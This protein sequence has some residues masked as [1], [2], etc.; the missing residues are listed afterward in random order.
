MKRYKQY[1]FDGDPAIIPRTAERHNL[2]LNT[3]DTEVQVETEENDLMDIEQD[4]FINTDAQSTVIEDINVENIYDGDVEDTTYGTTEWN[5]RIELSKIILN[6]ELNNIYG[7]IGNLKE[8]IEHKA[9][10]EKISTTM[11]KSRGEIFLMILKFSISNE[12]SFSGLINLFKLIN[13]MFETPILPDSRH[14]IDKLVNPKE[15][16]EYHVVCQECS[17]Y[18]GKIGDIPSSSICNVCNSTIN[19]KNN[20]DSTFFTLINPAQQISDL[21]SNHEDYF[22]YVTN[23]RVHKQGHISDVYDGKK[24]T[25]FVKSLPNEEK[26]NY[27]TAVFNTDGAPKFKCSQYSIWPLYLMI[28]ELPKEIRTNKLVVC[29]LL[30]TN[31]KPNMTVFL[32]KFVDLVNKCR[33]PIK[34]KN[35][36]RTLKIYVQ[37]C[38]VD[39]VARA[40]VQGL[41]QYNGKY[42]CNWCLHP[43]EYHGIMKYP[44]M[45]APIELRNHNDT[46]S[47]MLE[48]VPGN[49]RSSE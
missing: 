38:C 5:W 9:F 17:V 30:F 49:P 24:Y 13:S 27:V 46:V 40:P 41:T 26:D 22:Y 6:N 31:K 45:N 21:I 10:F 25:E 47:L 7:K 8:F 37:T 33:V 1:L 2:D 29:G 19:L 43:G 32:D 35:E 28:N 39:A 42:G 23:Q 18:L 14:I 15:G 12:L 36:Q 44:L 3:S 16:V 48:A 20:T 34:I 11:N 4:T